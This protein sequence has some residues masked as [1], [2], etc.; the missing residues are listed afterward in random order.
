MNLEEFKLSFL[1]MAEI[2]EG[3]QVNN[4]IIDPQTEITNK[5]KINIDLKNLLKIS[6]SLNRNLKSYINNRLEV[7]KVHIEIL[8]DVLRVFNIQSEINKIF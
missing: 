3:L 8:K 6:N 7:N 1:L 2:I 4:D 5:E